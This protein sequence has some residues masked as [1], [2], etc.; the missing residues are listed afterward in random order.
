MSLSPRYLWL[1]LLPGGALLYAGNIGDATGFWGRHGFVGNVLSGVTTGLMGAPFAYFFLQGLLR[2]NQRERELDRLRQLLDAN[3]RE[4]NLE[5]STF[6]SSSKDLDHIMG[7]LGNNAS[8]LNHVLVHLDALQ[9][10]GSQQDLT[11]MTEQQLQLADRERD[12]ALQLLQDINRCFRSPDWTRVRDLW[13]EI[14]SALT[15]AWPNELL[16]ERLRAEIAGIVQARDP[17]LA[18]FD[19]T[20]PSDAI[21]NLFATLSS[22]RLG[23]NTMDAPK[24]EKGAMIRIINHLGVLRQLEYATSS[25]R[26]ISGAS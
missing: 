25:E 1:L 24:V 6:S 11:G 20:R 12:E 3:M 23:T 16:P 15:Q 4:I 2:R 26:A 8:N 5:V 21:P 13:A 17:F 10:V 9:Q 7:A 18:I 19:E 22:G 14:T